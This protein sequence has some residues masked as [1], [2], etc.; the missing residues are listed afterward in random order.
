MKAKLIT[1]IASIDLFEGCAIAFLL[2]MAAIGYGM[3]S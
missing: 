1:F 3:L 2:S